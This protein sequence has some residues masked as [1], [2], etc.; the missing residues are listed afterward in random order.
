MDGVDRKIYGFLMRTLVQEYALGNSMYPVTMED[1][2]Q[3][4][5]LNTPHTKSGKRGT[6]SKDGI[7]D[8]SFVQSKVRGCWNCGSMDH[9]KKDC[10]KH[11]TDTQGLESSNEHSTSDTHVT[12]GDLVGTR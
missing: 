9:F 7:G 5:S 3:V 11:G 4:L 2:L 12:W 6:D 8:A 1:A 10:P